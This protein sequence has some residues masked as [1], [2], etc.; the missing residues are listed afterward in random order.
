MPRY[1]VEPYV[2]PCQVEDCD[3]RAMSSTMRICRLHYMRRWRE[4]HPDYMRQ[5]RER[6]PE[7]IAEYRRR[8]RASS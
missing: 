5:W 6:N 4:R 8:Y 2:G 7:R 3:R 1:V